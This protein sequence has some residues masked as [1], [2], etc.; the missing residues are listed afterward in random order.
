MLLFFCF[1]IF[2]QALTFKEWISKHGKRWDKAIDY[3][4][5][6]TEYLKVIKLEKNNKVKSG[7]YLDNKSK[8]NSK[9]KTKIYSDETQ[10]NY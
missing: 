2:T 9:L 10:D 4:K 5:D 7:I 3:L 6:K 1:I 8:C